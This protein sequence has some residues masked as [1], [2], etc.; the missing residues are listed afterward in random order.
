M[1]AHVNLSKRDSSNAAKGVLTVVDV[2]VVGMVGVVMYN[3]TIN[4][5]RVFG[6]AIGLTE[7]HRSQVRDYLLKR[8]FDCDM[9][10]WRPFNHDLAVAPR[11]SLL[12]LAAPYFRCSLQSL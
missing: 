8:A 10:I 2:V 7:I 9:K 12:P 1:S 6:T 3:L 11:H 4:S 5:N